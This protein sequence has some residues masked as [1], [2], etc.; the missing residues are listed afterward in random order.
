MSNLVISV[1]GAISPSNTTLVR[2]ELTD[3]RGAPVVGFGAAGAY[4][5]ASVSAVNASGQLT[6]DLEPNANITPAGTFYTVTIGSKSF[7]IL[8][9]ASTQTLLEALAP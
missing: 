4:T 5:E 6:L 1:K 9:S 8:K 2:V 3:E 7:L